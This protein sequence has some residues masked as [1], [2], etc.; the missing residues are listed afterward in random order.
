[1]CISDRVFRREL[2]GEG[3]FLIYCHIGLP[4]WTSRYH[5]GSNMKGGTLSSVDILSKE[6]HLFAE[7]S[8]GKF[9]GQLVMSLSKL[10]SYPSSKTIV[11]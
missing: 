7:E 5:M 4:A 3:E 10:N 6:Q 2:K 1:M 9:V 8:L 11:P